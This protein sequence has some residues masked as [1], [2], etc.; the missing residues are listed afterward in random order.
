MLEVVERLLVLTG[1]LCMIGGL[2]RAAMGCLLLALACLLPGLAV[3]VK[4]AIWPSRRGRH[5]R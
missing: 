1:T 2:G 3:Q 5:V 4:R